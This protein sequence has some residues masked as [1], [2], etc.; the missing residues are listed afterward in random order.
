MDP[1]LLKPLI[2]EV[3]DEFWRLLPQLNRRKL[4]QSP[5]DKNFRVIWNALY[6]SR[7]LRKVVELRSIESEH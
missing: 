1:K 6:T 2:E 7:A 3:D 5:E 4:T